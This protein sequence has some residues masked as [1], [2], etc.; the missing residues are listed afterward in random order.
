MTL[1]SLVKTMD[2][3]A[4]EPSEPFC[5]PSATD[6]RATTAFASPTLATNTY[7]SNVPCELFE[8]HETELRKK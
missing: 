7:T 2:F 4:L 1:C 8:M 5:D 6:D 3:N